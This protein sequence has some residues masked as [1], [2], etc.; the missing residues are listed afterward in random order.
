[1][2]FALDHIFIC[3]SF[4]AP[5]ANHLID[6]GLTEG[7][8]NTHPGQGTSCRR[9]FFHNAMLELLWLHN[10]EEA[11]SEIILPLRLYERCKYKETNASPF[12]IC[13]RPMNKGETDF[14]FDCWSY[15]PSYLPENVSM[16]IAES[17]TL[18]DEP[19]LF[20]S[21]MSVRQD[22]YTQER[23]QP[24][25]HKAGFREI[26]SVRITMPKS[27]AYSPAL[28]AINKMEQIEIKQGN[29]NLLELFFDDE[30]ENKFVDFRPE[31]PL[32]FYW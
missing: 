23:K 2:T 1:M 9:F 8:G 26:T 13:L 22:Q 16:Y 7:T 10:E 21:P 24:L 19:L 20:Y 4:E 29:E 15:C 5:E 25:E 6:F 11:K 30:K 3:A 27:E 17:S 14:P 12:G 31:L 32:L 28:R 18:V